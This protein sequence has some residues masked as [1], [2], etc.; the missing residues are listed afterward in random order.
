MFDFARRAAAAF[1]TTPLLG[2]LFCH[3]ALP[4]SSIA[5]K[6]MPVEM[7]GKKHWSFDKAAEIL[8]NQAFLRAN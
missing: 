2:L 5:S 4:A 8:I 1:P 7:S 6:S 3:A